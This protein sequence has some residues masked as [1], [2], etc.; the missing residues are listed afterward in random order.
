MKVSRALLSVS[1]KTGI[2]EFAK[3]LEKLGVEIIS[4]GG[5]FRILSEN[6]VKVH[7]IESVTGF[8]EIMD[9]RV[10]T[11]H[12]KI[13]GGLLAIRDNESHRKQLEENEIEPI[14]LVVV[15]L[16]PFQKTIEKEGV[17]LAEAIENIDIGGPTM[18]RSAAKNYRYVGVV[19]D[20]SDYDKVLEEL[21]DSGELSDET[22]AA[23][24]VKVFRMTADYDASIDHYL[25]KEIGGE[26]I[27]RLKYT[28]G[29]TLRYGENWHQ[30]ASFYREEG[31][32]FPNLG[33]MKKLAGKELSYNNYVD[34]HGAVNPVR[35]IARMGVAGWKSAVSVIKHTNPCGL[36]TGDTTVEALD[37]AWRGDQISA[38]GSII[39]CTMLF[40]GNAARYLK[41]KMV[42]VIIAPSFTEDA[43]EYLTSKSKSLILLE[44]D[45]A[46]IP[47][48]KM[49]VLK[50]VLGG[51]LEQDAD[52]ALF[53]RW[54]CVTKK[55]FPDEKMDLARFSMIAC[56]NTKSNSIILAEEY[57]PGGCHVLGMGAGQPNRVDSLRKLSVTKAR[58]NLGIA[59]DEKGI[60]EPRDEW[61]T[62]WLGEAVL[63]SDAFFPFD[64]T[65]REAAAAGIRYI[66]Q[67]GGSLRDEDSIK[68]CDELGVSMIFTGM[69]HFLH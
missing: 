45:V 4:T 68:A 63:A 60:N 48:L 6:G 8:P 14:D 15:N 59:Y 20:A 9:G 31:L 32:D 55:S 44:L 62:R 34:I 50:P 53:D 40:D 49:P 11:L 43:F 57:H 24:A 33:N 52:E 29:V 16:Y 19:T 7:S 12:P 64:D 17:E 67:P 51:M 38:F 21:E 30:K 28:C 3:G 46:A 61:I 22:R 18:L 54:E 36:A 26:D 2:V 69:R 37:Q 23:L 27:L 1:D 58:E 47:E 5:T 66:V 13:H 41:G 25:S 42:E 39:A 65:V 10:K 56:K 35:E